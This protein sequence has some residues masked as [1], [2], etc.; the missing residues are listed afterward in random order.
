MNMTTNT[1][2]LHQCA[3]TKAVKEVCSVTVTYIVTKRIKLLNS[4]DEM[5]SKISEFEAKIG[6]TQAIRCI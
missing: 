2:G 4:Q 1:F 3:P 5:L 6:M